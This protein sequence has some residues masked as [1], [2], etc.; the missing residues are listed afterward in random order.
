M[1]PPSNRLYSR[2][3]ASPCSIALLTGLFLGIHTDLAAQEGKAQDARKTPTVTQSPDATIYTVRFTGAEDEQV[4]TLL[5]DTLKLLR[6]GE[7]PYKTLG[8]LERRVQSHL[9]VLEKTLRAEGYYGARLDYHL[10]GDS[11]PI[12][13]EIELKHGPQ[14]TL[15]SYVIEYIG[16]GSPAAQLPVNPRE[17]GLNLGAPAR[18]QNIIDAEDLLLFELGDRGYPLAEILDREVVVDHSEH[19]MSVTLQAAPG[20]LARFGPLV[21]T[22]ALS[23]DP[24]YIRSFVPWDENEVF[25]Y[26]DLHRLRTSLLET[27]LFESVDVSAADNLNEQGLLPVLV[28]LSERKHRSIGVQM[29]WSTDTGFGG[30]VFW[31]HRNLSGKQEQL[32]LTA[33]LEEIKQEFSAAF[34]KPR[35]LMESQ[36]LLADGSGS[37]Q[38]T[39]AFQGPLVKFFTGLERRLSDTW[40]VSGG[41]PIEFSNLE[42]F[43]GTRDYQLLGISL[44]AN[45]DSADDALD[46]GQGSRL[47]LELVPLVGR[48]DEQ[49]SFTQGTAV[50]TAYFSLNGGRR[51]ILAGRAKLG[52]IAGEDSADL[53][54]Y[55]RFYAGGGASIRGYKFQSIGPLAPDGTP[56]GGRSVVE[57][58]TELRI[59]VTQTMGGVVFL[60]GGNVYDGSAPDFSSSL[61]WA[62]GFGVRYF[63]AVGPL[64]L[65]FGFPIDRRPIDD[66]FQFYISA[67]QAF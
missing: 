37:H 44:R 48:H 4:L 20:V 12:D 60:E 39:D 26:S 53:P 28:N 54:A 30:E 5:Q 43:L 27:G 17:L 36:S 21:V 29:H 67:G 42:D 56:R 57:L 59:K 19:S 49:V 25:V 6:S 11:G 24:K 18:A 65:D 10:K 22:G 8:G 16:Q 41:V 15:K 34:R 3:V 58:G 35:F 9:Q 40:T 32:T 38:D 61:R 66:S 62:A 45:H 13:I 14:Y 63:T 55:R 1:P 64:R 23:V 31:E 52:S 33:R 2:F 7:R 50:G 47:R 46:P 51:V